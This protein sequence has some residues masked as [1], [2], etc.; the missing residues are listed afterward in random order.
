MIGFYV[1]VLHQKVSAE[2]RCGFLALDG[3]VNVLTMQWKWFWLQPL[4]KSLNSHGVLRASYG[5]TDV[6]GKWIRFEPTW[7]FFTL[8]FLD[9]TVSKTGSV[10]AFNLLQIGAHLIHFFARVWTVR[11]WSRDP[12]YGLSELNVEFAFGRLF[13]CLS[14]GLNILTWISSDD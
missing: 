10:T 2:L 11:Y 14:G 8:T 9:S 6:P 4:L 12:E 5:K 1:D 7:F 13:Q 3:N